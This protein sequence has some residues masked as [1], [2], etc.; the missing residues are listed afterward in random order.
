MAGFSPSPNPPRARSD[1]EGIRIMKAIL[2]AGIVALGLS[3]GTAFATANPDGSAA[4][5]TNERASRHHR[6]V[7]RN[8]RR[9]SH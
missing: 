2:L 6:T 7:C 1:D 5:A 9:L 8:G 3:V 4:Q